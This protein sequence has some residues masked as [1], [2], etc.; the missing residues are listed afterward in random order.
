MVTDPE[1]TPAEQ[2]ILR[3]LGKGRKVP[4]IAYLRGTSINT[5]R[6]QIQNA[7]MRLDVKTKAELVAYARRRW[8][9]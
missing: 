8:P 9:V 4:Y 2:A 1:F 3:L 5:V 7:R 6:V